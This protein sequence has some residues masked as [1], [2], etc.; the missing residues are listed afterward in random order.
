MNKGIAEFGC[1]PSLVMTKINGWLK[2]NSA[3]STSE[4]GQNLQV[5]V[6]YRQLFHSPFHQWKYRFLD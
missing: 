4:A 5:E 2:I 3:V 1:P 6:L